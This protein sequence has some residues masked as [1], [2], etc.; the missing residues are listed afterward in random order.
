MSGERILVADD[1]AIIL[2]QLEESLN[3]MGY[4]VVGK[5]NSGATAISAAREHQPDIVLMDIVMPGEIDGIAACEAIQGNMNIPVVLLT[6]HSGDDILKRVKSVRP[7]GYLMKPHRPNQIRACIETTLCRSSRD[8]HRS[9]L[10]SGARHRNEDG[11]RQI[12]ATNRLVS[13]DLSMILALMQLQTRHS[14]LTT[15]DVAMDSVS[16]RVLSIMSLQESLYS[17]HPD[18]PLHAPSFFREAMESVRAS[19][20][21]P[22]SV[23][24]T[25]RGD[26]LAL[27]TQ[28]MQSLGLIVI[29]LVVNS[30]RHAFNGQGGNV[31]VSISG[32]GGASV[33]VVVSDDGKGFPEQ[34][35]YR[36]AETIGLDVVH[37]LV[38]RLGGVITQ[39]PAQGTAYTLTFPM[40]KLQETGCN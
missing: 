19:H 2:T 40:P 32:Q 11:K 12:N 24:V 17:G 18:K 26:D 16:K 35:V 25:L 23:R 5:A 29:E 33:R 27:P 22:E 6:A 20:F 28:Y 8:R 14:S 30:A 21:I 13:E 15:L 7:S 37:R 38:Q 39:H 34:P 31:L 1:E 36:N 9:N 4:H 3:E 10:L